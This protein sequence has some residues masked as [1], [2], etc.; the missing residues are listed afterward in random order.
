MHT[1][2]G[3]VAPKELDAM[4]N[5]LD[6]RMSVPAVNQ[7]ILRLRFVILIATNP[8]AE[9]YAEVRQNLHFIL[10]LSTLQFLFASYLK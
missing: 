5:I 1:I 4:E 2:T 10:P 3:N 8:Y 7:Q 6:V 9:Q